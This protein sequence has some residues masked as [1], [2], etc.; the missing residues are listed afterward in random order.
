MGDGDLSLQAI[1][2]FRPF[3][4]EFA[5]DEIWQNE[6]LER[7][8]D[9]LL[10][11]Y[12]AATRTYSRGPVPLS[13]HNWGDIAPLDEVDN[14]DPQK[15]SDVIS[16]L[17]SY[18]SRSTVLRTVRGKKTDYTLVGFPTYCPKVI[19][20]INDLP[21]TLQDRCIKIFLHRKTQSENVERFTPSAFD[22]QEG[23]RNQ[24]EAWSTRDALRII[25]AYGN[26]DLIGLPDDIDDRAKDLLEPLFAIASVLPKWVRVGLTQGAENLGKERRS[27]EAESNSVVQGL[28]ILIE[29]FPAEK[30]LW[31]LRTEQALE[32]FSEEIPGI[33]TSSQAQALLRRLG[34]RSKRCRI[35]N[36]VLRAYEIPRKRLKQLL[37]R[38]R[39]KTDAA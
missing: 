37:A 10:Q 12:R 19:A 4:A 35:G 23:L 7:T 31:R 3:V 2:L 32:F 38:Y 28:Q 25:G 14:L 27:Q 20:G 21:T 30:T 18:Y 9:N 34:F 29:Q 8:V 33:E 24:L 15:R 5:D 17:N 1:S 22:K 36:K 6:A 13:L 26:R 16:I 39:V 11:S